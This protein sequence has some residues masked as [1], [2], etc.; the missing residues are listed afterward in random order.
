LV[1]ALLGLLMALFPVA[2]ERWRS[3]FPGYMESSIGYIQA[4]GIVIGT[5]GIAF[6][7]LVVAL[8]R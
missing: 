3:R 7:L 5:F 6:V 2:E 1:F 4:L 8:G